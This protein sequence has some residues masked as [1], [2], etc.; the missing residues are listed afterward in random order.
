MKRISRL[1]SEG[2][3]SSLNGTLERD[4]ALRD[5]LA[6]AIVAYR[7]DRDALEEIEDGGGPPGGGP[8]R[9]KCAHA[10]VAHQ[11]VSAINPVGAL[12]LADA[13]WPDCREPCYDIA[14]S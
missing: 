13:G 14:G 6:A 4:G 10:H 3:M 2:W 11:I 9:V 8:D 5:R 7:A 1:E 12:A